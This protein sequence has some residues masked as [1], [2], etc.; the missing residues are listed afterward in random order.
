[1]I[2]TGRTDRKTNKEVSAFL[3]VSVYIVSVP[4]CHAQ[5]ESRIKSQ[6]TMGR[7]SNLIESDDKA[8][9]PFRVNWVRSWARRKLMRALTLRSSPWGGRPNPS[10][11]GTVEDYQDLTEMVGI[12]T[13]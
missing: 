6:G 7:L 3:S 10:L 13:K 4:R 1:M 8:Q 9:P 12:T 2:D 11:I 5:L